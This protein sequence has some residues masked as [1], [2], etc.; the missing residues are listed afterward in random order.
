M[1]DSSGKSRFASYRRTVVTNMKKSKK[2]A[3]KKSVCSLANSVAIETAAASVRQEKAR[4]KAQELKK[5][6]RLPA[7]LGFG[8]SADSQNVREA[9]DSAFLNNVSMDSIF[10]T[11]TGHAADMGQFPYT[12]FVGYGALQQIAQNGMIR[13]CIKTVADD[14]TRAWIKIKGGEGTDPQKIED[15]QTAQ[16]REFKLQSVFNRAIAKVG[17]MGGAF[18]FIKTE[19]NEETGGDV[20]L[21]LPLVLNRFSAEVKKGSRLSFIVVDPINVSPAAYN[22]YDPLRED[23][24]RPRE[25]LVLGK[26]VHA[27]RMLTMYANEPPVLLKP[28]YNFLG[29]PQAQILWDYV[30]HWNECRVASQELIKKLS[31]LIYYTNMQDRMASPN[32]VAE[33]DQIMEV[34]Q[35]YR[36]N[37]S[38]FVA[39]NDTD[40]VEN[41]S[42]TISGASEIVKQAQEMIAAINRTPAV[43][44]F[45]ISPS[46]F[47]ATG[48]S[49]LRNYNDHIRSQ[50]ELYRPAVQKCLDAI[51]LSLWGEID[52]GITFEWNELDMDN[53]SAQAMNFNSRMAALATL[54]DR[55]AISAEEMR[56]AA[57]QDRAAR[58]EWMG[59]EAPAEEND[60][61]MTDSGQPDDFL[62]QLLSGQKGNEPVEKEPDDGEE[63]QNGEGD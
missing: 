63:A 62:S 14:V 6:C 19:P 12:S 10:E 13:N 17:F 1:E 5:A 22:S 26:R 21:T 30:L 2:K 29:I 57:R 41:V 46:G 16:D 51:Q 8:T 58:L 39:N 45:G 50:Q 3:A 43:K 28:M 47:N 9:M 11:L 24:M 55:N 59:E 32:G 20:D 44:L 15:L 49:D 33:L 61:L 42:V 25:W 38:V 34:L 52:P 53:E 56:Q 27:S 60:E 35:H 7:T 18:V 40:R 36:S 23:Y 48:E 54:K 31:L 37:N 4:I